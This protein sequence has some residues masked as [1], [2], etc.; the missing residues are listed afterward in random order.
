MSRRD[1]LLSDIVSGARDNAIR[2]DALCG[3]L[4]ALGFDERTAGSHR[5]FSRE[6][7]VEL[8][9]IQPR[10]DGTAKPYQVKQV[11]GIITAHHLELP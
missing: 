10:S 11:R 3:L 1:K 6:G 7:V 2:F 5:I 8:I 9:N 4:A